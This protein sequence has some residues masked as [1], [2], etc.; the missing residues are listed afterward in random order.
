MARAKDRTDRA[1]GASE[2]MTDTTQGQD[3]PVAA[4]S[5][6]PDAHEVFPDKLPDA[7]EMFPDR[8]PS[9]LETVRNYSSLHDLVFSHPGMA[10]ARI[11]DAFGYGFKQDW[12]AGEHEASEANEY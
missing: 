1:R 10:H 4:Q 7:E 5:D 6:M 12:G 11:L 8:K 3:A 9:Y 2:P